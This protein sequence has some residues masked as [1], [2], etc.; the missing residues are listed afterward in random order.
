M[1]LVLVLAVGYT[2]GRVVGHFIQERNE[3]KWVASLERLNIFGQ[4]L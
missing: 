4:R 1:D 2:I 3:R